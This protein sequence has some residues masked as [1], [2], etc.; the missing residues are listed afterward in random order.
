VRWGQSVTRVTEEWSSLKQETRGGG[1]S[2]S[3]G[4]S[5]PVVTE[6]RWGHLRAVMPREKRCEGERGDS[7]AW[8]LLKRRDSM[9]RWC[10]PASRGHTA[11]VVGGG[12]LT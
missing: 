6:A 2:E 9:G 7:S 5:G 10:G 4:Q 12:G 8:P 11:E 3:S 1:G